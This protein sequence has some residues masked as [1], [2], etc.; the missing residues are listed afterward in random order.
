M[1]IWWFG[2]LKFNISKENMNNPYANEEKR[3]NTSEEQED[4]F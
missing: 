2:A 1:R 3:I 4:Y